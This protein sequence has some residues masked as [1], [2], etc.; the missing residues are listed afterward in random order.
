M[1][2]KEV[3]HQ[4]AGLMRF[5]IGNPA[6]ALQLLRSRI[7]FLRHRTLTRSYIDPRGY[8]IDSPEKL[9]TWWA[10]FIDNNLLHPGWTES[11]AA[12]KSPQVIDIGAN[13]GVFIHVLLGI[14]SSTRITAV[15]PQPKLVALIEDYARQ[16]KADIRCVAVACSDREGQESLFLANDGDVRASLDPKFAAHTQQIKVPI[17]TVDAIAPP[18]E[19][20]LMKVDAEGHDIQVL[21]GATAT[22]Q[23]TQF[24]LIEAHKPETLQEAKSVLHKWR[25]QQ[26]GPYDFLF[27]STENRS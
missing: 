13:A 14:N 23:R 10:F 27:S 2:V 18:G 16:N 8:R 17:T 20:L 9:F 19:I 1:T 4:A 11:L 7:D 5:S 26:V 6:F 25:C 24:I 15:E 21:K 3:T 12:A 22:L